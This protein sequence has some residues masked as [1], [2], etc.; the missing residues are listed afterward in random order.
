MRQQ[1]F[2]HTRRPTADLAG[3]TRGYFVAQNTPTHT[4]TSVMNTTAAA[5]RP[6]TTRGARWS[7]KLLKDA[8]KSRNPMNTL[9]IVMMSPA[10][11][12]VYLTY[13]PLSS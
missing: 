11:D 4:G 13:P 8:P 1:P 3:G 2:Q 5:N 9:A 7:E 6:Q 12:T 10:S